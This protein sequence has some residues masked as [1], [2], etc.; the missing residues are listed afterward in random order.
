MDFLNE[1]YY[2]HF[3]EGMLPP[4]KE[5]GFWSITAYGSDEFLIPNEINRYSV[6]NRDN[7]TY[8]PDGSLDILLQEDQ[9]EEAMMNNW[10]PLGTDNF[11]LALRM[12]IPDTEKIANSWKIPEI[13]KQQD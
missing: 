5:P 7:L 1:S 4:V 9:P 13:V 2:I 11:H 3:A 12:Y 8:N 6:N 10:L